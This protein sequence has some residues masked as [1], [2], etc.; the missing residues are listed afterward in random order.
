MGLEI[1]YNRIE[2]RER[3]PF[4]FPEAASDSKRLRD[5]SHS[6]YNLRGFLS[7]EGRL[8]GTA[9]KILLRRIEKGDAGIPVHNP[10]IA[11][12]NLRKGVMRRKIGNLTKL[13]KR[14]NDGFGSWSV[15]RAFFP[16]GSGKDS[17]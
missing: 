11:F 8:C 17:P 6:R 12:G 15:R 14:E 10:K 7:E 1:C 16:F 2:E 5:A 4:R 9:D 3:I 13:Q